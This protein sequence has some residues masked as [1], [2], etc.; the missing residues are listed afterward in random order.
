[1]SKYAFLKHLRIPKD[2]QEWVNTDLLGR[3]FLLS[4]SEKRKDSYNSVQAGV[5][6][7]FGVNW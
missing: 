7:M 3:T 6:K 2:Y 4:D 5:R 1:V